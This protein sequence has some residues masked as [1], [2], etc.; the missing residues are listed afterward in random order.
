MSSNPSLPDHRAPDTA[1]HLSEAAL[2]VLGTQLIEDLDDD[3]MP[4]AH[5]ESIITRHKLAD[6][7]E[8]RQALALTTIASLLADQTILVGDVV[9]GDPAYIEPWPGTPA[10]ILDRIRSLYIDHYNDTVKWDLRIW[11]SLND[12]R[13]IW[14][15]NSIE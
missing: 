1:G 10:E 8:A 7:A 15:H 11:F 13:K 2:A 4:M 6:T 12:E 5:V 3:V 9:G 14:Q